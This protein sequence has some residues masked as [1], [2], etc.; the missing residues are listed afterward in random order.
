MKSVWLLAACVAALVANGCTKVYTEQ[1]LE[2]KEQKQLSDLP[3]DEK[4]EEGTTRRVEEEGGLG[5][6]AVERQGDWVDEEVTN[7]P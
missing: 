3:E 4:E 1:A 6:E 7:T 2:E 5:A